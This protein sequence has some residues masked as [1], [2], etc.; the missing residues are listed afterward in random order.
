MEIVTEW[1]ILWSMKIYNRVICGNHGK[2]VQVGKEGALVT[3]VI[4]PSTKEKVE[5]Y[6]F[7]I[8]KKIIKFMINLFIW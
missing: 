3:I 4:G 6:L 8:R 5:S 1:I 2:L 7:R